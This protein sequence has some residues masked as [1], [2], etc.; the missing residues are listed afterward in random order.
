MIAYGETRCRL[1]LEYATSDTAT[2]TKVF[3]VNKPA[4]GTNGNLVE[5]DSSIVILEHTGV[6][7]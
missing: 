5:G 6:L 3:T 2:S 1:T 4:S 7:A